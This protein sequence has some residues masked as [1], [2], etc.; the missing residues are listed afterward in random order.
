MLAPDREP[1]S[2]FIK[3]REISKHGRNHRESVNTFLKIKNAL[4]R[5]FVA[6]DGDGGDII[7]LNII[8]IDFVCFIID[9]RFVR[10]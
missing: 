2:H 6:T 5:I 1:F 3:K 10:P 7:F 9:S 4:G 8:Y